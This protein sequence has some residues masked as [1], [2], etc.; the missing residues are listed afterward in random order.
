MSMPA[1]AR[2]RTWADWL[3]AAL[4]AL[5]PLGTRYV[6]RWGEL[7]GAPV[8]YGTLSLWATQ[9][10]AASYVVTVA[11]WSRGAAADKRGRVH[12]VPYLVAAFLL[13]ATTSAF[14]SVNR[15]DAFQHV[16]WLVLVGGVLWAASRH[17]PTFTAAATGWMV[18]AALQ[19]LLA[20][21]QFFA[22]EV[23]SSTLLGMAAHLPESPGTSVVAMGAERWL[24]AYGT[25]SHPNMLGWYAAVG[26][27]FAVAWFPTVRSLRTRYALVAA[28]ALTATGLFL[29]FSRMAWIFLALVW[30]P[31]LNTYASHW[32]T[33][34]TRTLH[35]PPTPEKKSRRLTAFLPPILVAL[36]V[37][38]VLAYAYAPLL[39]TRVT[40]D[41]PLEQRSINERVSQVGEAF[42]LFVQKPLIGVGPGQFAATG[43]A[44]S[45]LEQ[46]GWSFQPVHNVPLLTAVELGAVGFMLALILVLRYVWFA[47]WKRPAGERMLPFVVAAV[48]AAGMLD[49]FLWSFWPGMLMGALAFASTKSR[50]LEEQGS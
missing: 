11:W 18:G 25:F 48:L 30:I 4:V 24:R 19:S 12:R 36:G 23:V 26:L 28:S 40:A 31:L 37:F 5:A 13:L 17:R 15:L 8:E 38:A 1:D 49:H 27:T 9:L 3:F 6:F 39:R 21:W 32:R 44:Q 46:S 33:W 34:G 10:L 45:S 7:N 43:A 29:S 50:D 14:Y 35:L 41:S 22:Q 16:A 47:L 2:W 42:M 20:V